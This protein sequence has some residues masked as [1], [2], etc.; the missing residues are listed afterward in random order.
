MTGHM[1]LGFFV[2]M[3]HQQHQTGLC[4]LCQQFNDLCAVFRIQ[5]AGRFIS[6]EDGCRF[7]QR[8]CDAQPLLLSA[9]QFGC[10][11]LLQLPQAH[12]LQNFLRLLPCLFLIHTGQPQCTDH[13]HQHRCTGKNAVVLGNKAD[14]IPAVTLPIRT[15][16]VGCGTT[17]YVHFAAFIGQ[18]TAKH[19]GKCGFAAAA[20]AGDGNEFSPLE[21][22]C[23][24]V[25]AH[26]HI[27]AGSIKFTDR[28][29]R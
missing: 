25:E 12:L 1:I 27:L 14:I 26:D 8:S 19:M 3:G 22:Q 21:G 2:F 20:F 28:F 29:Q 4:R 16:I 18:N 10:P 24:A 6:N 5:V 23:D 17:V 7:C 9:G 15:V 11:A 13:I